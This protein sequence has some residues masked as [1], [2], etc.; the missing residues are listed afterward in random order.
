MDENTKR[1]L[2]ECLK[3]VKKL[4]EEVSQGL[5][6]RSKEIKRIEDFLNRVKK[7]EEEVSQMLEER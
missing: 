5:E 1:M 2:E 6:E 4:E 3:N 7:L